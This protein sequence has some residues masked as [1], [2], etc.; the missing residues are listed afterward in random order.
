MYGHDKDAR[1]VNRK[2]ST[3]NLDK[4]TLRT[5]MMLNNVT[6]SDYSV[7][8]CARERQ[9]QSYKKVKIELNELQVLTVVNVTDTNTGV[10]VIALKWIIANKQQQK[11]C[12]NVGHTAKCNCNL[13]FSAPLYCEH[14]L[15]NGLRLHVLCVDNTRVV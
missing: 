5:K 15:C 9:T 8:V 4:L 3:V 1:I 11:V 10:N 14:A 6:M 2:G 7:C 12:L 13:H